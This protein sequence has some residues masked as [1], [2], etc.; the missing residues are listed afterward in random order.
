MMP[1]RATGE[2]GRPGPAALYR[3]EQQGD[4]PAICSCG[5]RGAFDTDPQPLPGMS[6]DKTLEESRGIEQRLKTF[7]ELEKNVSRTGQIGAAVEARGVDKSGFAGAWRCL[8][9]AN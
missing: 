2:S 4:R 9:A 3:R 6:L 7:P 1:C 5:A 8:R